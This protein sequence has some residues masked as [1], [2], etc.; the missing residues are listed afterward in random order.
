MA[1][2]LQI[3]RGTSA[4]VAA[5]TGAEGEIVVNT[6]NDSV[7]VNDGSTAGGFELARVD[8]SNWA[9]TNAISTTAN[10]SFGDND[11]AI[12]G[13]GS[14]LQIYHDGSASYVQDTGTGALYLQGDGGV[15][16]RNAAGTENKA[17]FASDGAVTL[18][19]DN[20][21]RFATTS[22]GI[23]VTG[24]VT[25]DGL[26]VDGVGSVSANT[27]S[28]AGSIYNAN[29][30]GNVL[31]LRSGSVGGTTAVLGIFDGNNNEKARFTASGRLGIGTS[32]PSELLHINRASGTGA[33][34][35]IQD[36]SGGNY[37]GTDGGVL[38]FFDGSASEKM[39]IDSSGN[40]GIGGNGTGTGLGVYLSKGT[41]ANFF[42]ASDGTKTMITGSDSTQDFVKIGSLSAHPV[43]FVVGNGEKMR[44]DSSGNVSIG[45]AS[46]SARLHV[47]SSAD[48]TR[49]SILASGVTG[50]P[51]FQLATW[52]GIGGN[53]AGSEVVR[54]GLGYGA[55]KNSYIHFHRGGST[56]GGFMS[57]STYNGTERM[58]L[59]SVG[60]WMVSNTVANV[61][62]NY[63][64]QGGCGWV[65][66]DNHFEIAT[67]SNTAALEI[68]KNNA[69]DGA[70]ITFRKQSTP[71][72]S[73]GAFVGYSY[74]GN[75]G[76]QSNGIIFTPTSIEPF[77]S[78]TAT[79]DKDGDI[80]LGAG[81]QRFQDLYLSGQVVSN[82]SNNTVRASFQVSG[83]QYGY[84]NVA[85]TGTLYSTTSDYRIKENVVG[86]TNATERL[87]QLNPLRFSFIPDQENTIVDG[88][89]AHEV[90]DVV[91][92]A[93]TGTKDAV[94]D[95]GNAVYQ[96]ID[97]S[98]LVPL[99]VAT[100]QEL[101]ARI[102]QLE[103]N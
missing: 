68:G 40:V 82:G 57:F 26:T 5:F 37:I 53:S 99:L 11:K 54:V 14:D 46:A 96:G 85:T 9:I 49:T 66:S 17:V 41:G 98:K 43:G 87:Q 35:R 47:P 21:A 23:D 86:L 7:H 59:N 24:T 61:A 72:G 94:D 36:A 19:F 27:T 1:T 71:V 67:T 4:Q 25:A 18:Y 92:E 45:T 33:Y 51:N 62:S 103:N 42:E 12:F 60:D 22:S 100:I 93:I 29:T 10:I 76:T 69:N 13:A 48:D 102:T 78:S 83:T 77:N 28:N 88:F 74:I 3:R 31:K 8:G 56:I 50:D 75:S 80:D 65:E 70:I 32:S 73:I 97:Q 95:D 63:S 90:A 101:E 2:Q 89:F 15:N 39:R 20:T 81:N 34:I 52:S 6:T 79:S 64:A 38:Q 16:I 44:I 91:P 55:T 84:I 58:R 30:S